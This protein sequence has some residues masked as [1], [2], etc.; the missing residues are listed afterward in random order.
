MKHINHNARLKVFCSESSA[1]LALAPFILLKWKKAQ[2]YFVKAV[3]TIHLT[4]K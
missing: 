1:S 3:I 2:Q 4:E